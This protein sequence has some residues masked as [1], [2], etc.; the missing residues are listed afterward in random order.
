MLGHKVVDIHG[1][2]NVLKI[3]HKR[4]VVDIDLCNHFLEWKI[5]SQ[6]FFLCLSRC[7]CTFVDVFPTL[8]IYLSKHFCTLTGVQLFNSPLNQLKVLFSG[9]E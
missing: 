7:V 6:S 3:F 9:L 2:P 4:W 1:P 8:L 5:I